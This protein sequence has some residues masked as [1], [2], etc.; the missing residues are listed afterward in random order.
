MSRAL[1]QELIVM[2]AR[3]PDMIAYILNNLISI[4]F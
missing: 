2:A 1:S 4:L 3:S